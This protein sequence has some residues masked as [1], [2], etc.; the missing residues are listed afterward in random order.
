MAGPGNIFCVIELGVRLVYTLGR[1]WNVLVRVQSLNA[2]SDNSVI[3][4]VVLKLT[5]SPVTDEPIFNKH[6]TSL[7]YMVER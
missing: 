7:V 5:I 4:W 1:F 2:V 3:G 6:R